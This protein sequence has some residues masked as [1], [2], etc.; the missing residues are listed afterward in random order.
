[1]N[2]IR[3]IS[4][5]NYNSIMKNIKKPFSKDILIINDIEAECNRIVTGIKENILQRLN[6][7]GGVIGISGGID[8]AVTMV[9]AVKGLGPEN[10]LGNNAA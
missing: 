5:A 6:R 1:M 7:R 4:D 10:V 9:L 8:S 3:F 2:K